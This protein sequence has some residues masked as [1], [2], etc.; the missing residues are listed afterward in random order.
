M[1][2]PAFSVVRNND[3]MKLGQVLEIV[4]EQSDARVL[5]HRHVEIDTNE[6]LVLRYDTQFDRGV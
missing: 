6:L 1:A 3:Y 5:A 4:L 2:K